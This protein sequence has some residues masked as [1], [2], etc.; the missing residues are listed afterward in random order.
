MKIPMTAPV[1]TNITHGA[2][3]DCESL[4]EM[5]F[6]IPFDLQEDTPIPTDPKLYITTLPQIEAYVK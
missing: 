4:F 2:G 3:P 1:L 6:M 5:H